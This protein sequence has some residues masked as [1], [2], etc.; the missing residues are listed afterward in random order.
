MTESETDRA[1]LKRVNPKRETATRRAFVLWMAGYAIA[2]A[3]LG[4]LY[5][6]GGGA[7]ITI[8]ANGLRIQQARVIDAPQSSLADRM[9]LPQ[10]AS[11][12]IDG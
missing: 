9:I 10:V 12:D 3:L 4:S 7:G 8:D 11:R 6:F 1:R 2:L 5:A